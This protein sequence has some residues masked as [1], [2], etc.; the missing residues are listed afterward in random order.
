MYKLNAY[1][2]KQKELLIDVF[3]YLLFIILT[4]YINASLLKTY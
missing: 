1:A 4:N 2:K 3:L